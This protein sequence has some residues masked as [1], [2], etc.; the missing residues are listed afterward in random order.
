MMQTTQKQVLSPGYIRI[1]IGVNAIVPLLLIILDGVRGNLGANPLEFYLRATG[2]LTLI[3]LLLTLSV[4]PLRRLTGWNQVIK[5]RRM[6]GLFAFFYAV[7]NA[8][9]YAIFDMGLDVSAIVGDIAQRPF[10]TVGVAAF[11]ML[12]PLAVTSAN[13]WV[14][15]LGG[16]NWSRLHRLTYLIAILGVL[17]FWML[18]KS[19]VSYPAI[20]GLV[21]LALLGFRVVDHLKK[22]KTMRDGL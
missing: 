20:A 14:K 17:H 15:R 2:V 9:A 21:L 4:T 13:R 8:T 19:D 12:L 11:I 5:F 6:L 1:L 3:F 18:V 7:L 10:I 16:R 22:L